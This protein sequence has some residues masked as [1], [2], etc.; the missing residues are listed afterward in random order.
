MIKQF[1]NCDTHCH[2]ISLGPN[3]DGNTQF[4]CTI[5]NG[6]LLQTPFFKLMVMLQNRNVKNFY[7]RIV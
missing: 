4:A 3:F 1:G 2:W 7:T 5:E 6:Q